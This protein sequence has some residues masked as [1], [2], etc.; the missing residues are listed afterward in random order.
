MK[1]YQLTYIISPQITSQEAE[2][3][4]KELE[5]F[6][7]ANEGVILN[8]E[9]PSAKALAYPIKKHAS[10]FVGSMEFQMEEDRI[11]EV[12]EKLHKDGK[13]VRHML[14]IKRISKPKKEREPRI[15]PVAETPA[16]AP[17]ES[18][19]EAKP[20]ETKEKE[21]VELKDIDQQIDE[22]LGQ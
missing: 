11:K 21:K 1:T 9:N 22:I 14:T 6:V 17:T 15:K 4:A 10:G 12:E 18:L 19:S 13:M 20:A 5:S 7:Q 8:S 2:L 16:P 3:S